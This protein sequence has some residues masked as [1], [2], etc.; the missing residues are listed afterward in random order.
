MSEVDTALESPD[1]LTEQIT[2][3]RDVRDRIERSTLPLATSVDGRSFDFQASLH[4]LSLRRGAYVELE[5]SGGR[6]F[7]QI[8]DLARTDTRRRTARCGRFDHQRAD[9]RGRGPGPS[10]R[11]GG[12]IPRRTGQAG[13]TRRGERLARWNQASGPVQPR[14]RGADARTRRPGRSRQW[15]VQPPHLHVRAVWLGED[16]LAGPPPG[17][18]ACRDDPAHRD[19]R[20]QLRLRRAGPRARRSRHG[21]R[22]APSSHRPRRRRVEQRARRRAP[23]EAAVRRSGHPHPGCGPGDRPDRGPGRVRRAVRPAPRERERAVPRH[24]PRPAGRIVGPERPAAGHAGASTW[25]S[26]TG[27]SGDPRTAPSWRS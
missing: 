1:A 24:Q 18:G 25:A 6:R 3:Y 26:S 23:A 12:T 15:W 13:P 9:P 10:P 27:R 7:G 16:V 11:P 19:P 5:H 22:R 21:A 14:R 8:T 4:G 2:H 20:P 17:A